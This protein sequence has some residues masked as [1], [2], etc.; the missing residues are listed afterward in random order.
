MMK[1]IVEKGADLSYTSKHCLY[2]LEGSQNKNSN[3]AGTWSQ[4]LIQRPCMSV[5]Y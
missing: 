5:A 1:S 3:R 4:E 2:I